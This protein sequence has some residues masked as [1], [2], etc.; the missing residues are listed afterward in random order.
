MSNIVRGTM[1]LTGA[2]FLSKFLGMIY[3][4]PFYGLVGDDGGTL[5]SLAYIPYNI[6]LSISIVGVPVA[7]SKFVSK[8]NSL[9]D[10]ETGLRIFKA[11]IKLMAITGFIAF[12]ALFLSADIIAKISMPGETAERIAEG[13]MVI[14][15]VSFALLVIPAMSIVRGFFQ[16]YQSMGPTAVSQVVEQIIRIIF[17]LTAAF[18]VIKIFDGSVATAVGF[19]TFATFIGGLASCI[20]LWFYWKKRKPGIE[21]NLQNQT[22]ASDI[23]TGKLMRE[24]FQYA[25]PVLLVGLATPLYQLVDQGTFAKAM[26]DIGETDTWE[27]GFSAIT[28]YGHKIIMIPVTIA[29]GLS[30]AILPALTRAFTQNDTNSLYHQINQALQIVLVLIIPAAVGLATLS[31]VA[32]GSLYSLDNIDITGELLAWYAPVALLIALFT[33]TSSI[34]Q[35]INQQNFAVVSLSGGLLLKVLFNIPLIHAFG[36]KG[37]IFGTAL[38][39]GTAVALNLW[40][41]KKSIDIS[42]KQTFKRTLLVLI[43]SLIMFILVSISKLIF[44]TFLS[45]EQSRIA[46]VVMLSIGILIGG[47]AYLWFGYHSTLLERVLGNRVHKL[48]RFFSRRR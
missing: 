28:L 33:V 1:L 46:A 32:Y 31:D 44:G 27:I 20:V 4:I 2:T 37:A 22:Y 40:R 42:Y 30:L 25:G 35:G 23:S 9:H 10:Y 19:A 45:Y 15:M 14:R 16:G 47:Y 8:Y 36:A 38:A 17:L 43:F 13:A 12:L 48:E 3:V 6:L 26:A 34:L 39:A 5:Y 11:G 7:V 21:R 41:V 18:I 24:L 29:T